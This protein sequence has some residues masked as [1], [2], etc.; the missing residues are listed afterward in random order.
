M[1]TCI[2]CTNHSNTIHSQNFTIKLVHY[3][4]FTQTFTQKKIHPMCRAHI[5][6]ALEGQCSILL[7]AVESSGLYIIINDVDKP[8]GSIG[9]RVN[10]KTV[11]KHFYFIHSYTNILTW[12]LLTGSS[13]SLIIIQ[14]TT[15]YSIEQY[16]IFSFKPNNYT[17]FTAKHT[18]F[19]PIQNQQRKLRI[20]PLIGSAIFKYFKVSFFGFDL[21]M[22]SILSYWG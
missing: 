21:K 16:Q 5:D 11:H 1:H 3:H 14:F 9:V 6:L 20:E 8:V 7:D 12:K 13:T 22:T 18:Q 17:Y 10:Q 2:Y 19:C 4:F 15:L